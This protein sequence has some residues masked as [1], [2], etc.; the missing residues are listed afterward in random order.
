V[1]AS[2][3]GLYGLCGHADGLPLC[4]AALATGRLCVSIGTDIS[5]SKL[6]RLGQSHELAIG[7]PVWVR[8]P[9]DDAGR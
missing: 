2:Q 7:V 4:D 9:G 1:R 5:R 3:C 6:D 8:C